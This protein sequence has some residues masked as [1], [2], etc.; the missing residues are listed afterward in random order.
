MSRRALGIAVAAAIA[1]GAF[2]PF[3]F[4]VFGIPRAALHARLAEAQY[5]KLPG[6]RRFLEGVRARTREGEVVAVYAPPVHG[7]AGPAYYFY[8]RS[9]YPL[10]GRRV[11]TTPAGADC[12]AAYRS[13]PRVPG[14]AV[15]W[16]SEDGVLLRRAR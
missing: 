5:A 8:A 16:R 12:I 15:A 9:L 6:S 10:A 13:E 3:Y 1:A 7:D 11:V 4:R 14:F 2:Q